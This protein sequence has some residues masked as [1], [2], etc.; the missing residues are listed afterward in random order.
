M[1]VAP[2]PPSER[3]TGIRA[4]LSLPAAYR[5]AQNLIGA[6]RFRRTLID[7]FLHVAPGSRV[8]DIGCGTADIV[9]HLPPVDYVGF[10]H[11]HEYIE[12]ARARFSG[13]GRFITGTSATDD[14]S[15]VMDRD[16]AMAIGVLHHLDDS[17]AT[18]A[19]RLAHRAL[20]PGGRFVSIDPTFAAGQH[21]IGRWLAG[22]DRG[23][24]VRTPEETFALVT[25]VFSEAAVEVRHDLLRI[26]YSHVVCQARRS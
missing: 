3:V 23:Q 22:R 16:V 26:P 19:L 7:E 15:D 8:L 1:A 25:S 10:D 24:H 4:L 9:E 2:G 17:G 12:S 6:Q 14:L 11:S 18:D 20:R 21:P 5:L 13:R